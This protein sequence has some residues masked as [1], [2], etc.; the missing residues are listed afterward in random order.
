MLFFSRHAGDRKKPDYYRLSSLILLHPKLGSLRTEIL[1]RPKLGFQDFSGLKKGLKTF[2][3]LRLQFFKSLR[4]SKV[5]TKTALA[6]AKTKT[7]KK[8]S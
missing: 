5:K 4:P 3:V 7:L 8:W 6:K 2:L 1:L